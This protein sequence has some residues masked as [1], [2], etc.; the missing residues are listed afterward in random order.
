LKIGEGPETQCVSGFIGFDIPPPAGPLWYFLPTLVR[1]LWKFLSVTE[2]L[3]LASFNIGSL[4]KDLFADLWEE[5]FL[6]MA[7]S[8]VFSMYDVVYVST[9][10]DG[11]EERMY[12]LVLCDLTAD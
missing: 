6:A 7:H 5:E 4:E 12:F 10:D 8:L 9:L 1:H 3:I 11:I 2:Q